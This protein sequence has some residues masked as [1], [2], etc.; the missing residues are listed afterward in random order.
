MATIN[1]LGPIKRATGWVLDKVANSRLAK[2]SGTQVF[3]NNRDFI[4]GLGVASI[5]AK[6][7]LGCYLYVTQS[8]NNKNIPDD[9][10]KFVASL[11]LTNGLLMILFQIA[12]FKMS[13]PLLTKLFN[14]TVGKMFERPL[15]KTYHAMVKNKPEFAD[16]S[17]PKFSEAFAKVNNGVKDAFIGI[18]S[19]A[20]AAIVGKRMLVPLVATPLAGSVEK[21]MNEREAKKNGTYVENKATDKS[22]PSMQGGMKESQPVAEAQPAQVATHFDTG[23]TNLLDKYRKQQ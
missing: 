13:K 23:S 15:R 21:W 5:I 16:I 14:K 7:G 22:Q 19:L 18:M 2:Y 9:K 11:D 1:R 3:N 8:L 4:D 17:G 10:R 6:D 12:V 20:S